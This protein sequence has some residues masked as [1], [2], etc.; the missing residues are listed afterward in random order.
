M[1]TTSSCC[2]Y[3]IFIQVIC[4]RDNSI[5]L[6]GHEDIFRALIELGAKIDVENENKKTPRQIAA[7]RSNVTISKEISITEHL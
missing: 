3:Q 6:S 5:I 1:D 4:I 7:E 2:L